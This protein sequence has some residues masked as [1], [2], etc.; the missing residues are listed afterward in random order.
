M[1]PLY[2]TMTAAEQGS[3]IIERESAV[4]IQVS[5]T[6]IERHM[7]TYEEQGMH[8]DISPLL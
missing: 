6:I 3:N 7:V 8:Q 5:V 2:Y 1:H 4:Q